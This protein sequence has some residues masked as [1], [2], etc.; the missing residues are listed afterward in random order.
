M[1]PLDLT[2]EEFEIYRLLY[3]KA[4]F[5][6]MLVK[7]TLDQ[8]VVDS[9]SKLELTKKKVSLI[10]KRFISDNLLTV[11]RK[12]SKGNP[13]IYE[14]SNIKDLNL[15][16]QKELKGT[17]RELKGNLKPSNGEGL[18]D[19]EEHKGNLKEHKGNTKV[20]PIKD[21]EKDKENIYSDINEIRKCYPGKKAKSIADRKLPKLVKQYGKEQLINTIRRYKE[22]VEMQRKGG[23]KTLNFKN[24]GT[25]WNGGYIDYLD[26][27]YEEVKETINQPIKAT[28]N[29]TSTVDTSQI[30]ITKLGE[31]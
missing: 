6:T 28:I 22:D 29:A 25:F 9:N 21:K 17:Q 2:T 8:L 15:G 10:T 27:N 30:D 24:E 11:I 19:G 14:I 7:Y 23:F 20:T 26:E 31:L 4:D 1:A 12:G 13:T 5:D 18:H 3:K 16:T